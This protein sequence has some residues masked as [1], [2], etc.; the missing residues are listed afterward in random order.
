MPWSRALG[1]MVLAAVL[2]AIYLATAPPP[3]PLVDSA[4]PA[5]PGLAI[6]SV[7][8]DADGRT[9]RAT[10]SD[11]RWTVVEPATAH[12]PSDLI[13]ALV[14]AVLE[15]EAQP[16]VGTGDQLVD[17]GL[18]AP[19]TR[20]VFD[21]ADGPP[22][23]VSIGNTNPTETGIYARL[24]GNPQVILLGL[25]VRYYVDLVLKASAEL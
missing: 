10:R 22:V 13:S 12:V 8:I 24:E 11:E 7:R 15:T 16:V 23:T 3:P 6:E 4:E 20:L 21:R 25:N 9:V 18:D 5:A 14:S 17:F 2:G 19:S 1:Y